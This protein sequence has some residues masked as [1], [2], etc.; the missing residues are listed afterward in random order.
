MGLTNR[1]P[2]PLPVLGYS[3]ENALRPAP[4]IILF[5]FDPGAD[6]PDSPLFPHAQRLNLTKR[7]VSSPS[8]TPPLLFDL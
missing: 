8:S 4:G 2:R 6:L 1:S 7:P 3:P 5:R